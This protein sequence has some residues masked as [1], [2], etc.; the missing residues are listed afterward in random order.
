MGTAP[1]KRGVDRVGSVL[2]VVVIPVARQLRV[3][4]AGPQFISEIRSQPPALLPR[5]L[6]TPSKSRDD[7]VVADVGVGC[8]VGV[9]PLRVALS[10]PPVEVQ[11]A[12]SGETI[13]LEPKLALVGAGRA[14]FELGVVRAMLVLVSDF[15]ARLP[16]DPL[17]PGHGANPEV[18]LRPPILGE[19]GER[20]D[21]VFVEELAKIEAGKPVAGQCE[22][23]ITREGFAPQSAVGAEIRGRVFL[24]KLAGPAKAQAPGPPARHYIRPGQGGRGTQKE[25]VARLDRERVRHETRLEERQLLLRVAEDIVVIDGRERE[26]HAHALAIH[27]LGGSRT[28]DQPRSRQKPYD[29][30]HDPAVRRSLPIPDPH[31]SSL[32]T[33]GWGM[34][35]CISTDPFL[36]SISSTD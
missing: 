4:R 20:W 13:H 11:R 21:R 25:V 27:R 2:P 18:E 28:A 12:P 23:P 15:R 5:Q 7:S 22:S 9:G 30:R 34:R 17:P 33:E 32:P 10:I 3:V 24:V 31:H 16:R 14:L 36:G 19:P 6:H 8:A 35:A 26:T 1:A 29:R